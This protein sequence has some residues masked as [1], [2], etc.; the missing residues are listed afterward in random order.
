MIL[1]CAH[2][3][4]ILKVAHQRKRSKRDSLLDHYLLRAENEK[5]EIPLQG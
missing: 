1:I 5:D 4:K 3:A 2:Y